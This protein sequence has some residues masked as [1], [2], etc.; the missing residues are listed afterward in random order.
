MASVQGM[1]LV[2]RGIVLVVHRDGLANKHNV[3]FVLLRCRELRVALE[4][5][6]RV[7]S[8]RLLLLEIP[9]P[10]TKEHHLCSSRPGSSKRP[11]P[12]DLPRHE[13]RLGHLSQGTGR[14]A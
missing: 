13:Y 11:R 5:F 8:Q 12:K 3:L 2:R 4:S 14:A 9:L 7:R 1:Y 6:E 10:S